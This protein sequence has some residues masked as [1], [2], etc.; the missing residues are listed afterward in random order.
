[1]TQAGGQYDDVSS[2]VGNDVGSDTGRTSDESSTDESWTDV[3]RKLDRRPT[4][5]GRKSNGRPTKVGRVELS[6][7]CGDGGRR[8]FLPTLQ[9]WPGALQLAVLLWRWPAMHCSL[10]R[11]CG[12]A[13]ATCWTSQRCC[14][15]QQR[16]GPHGVAAMAG[17]ALD[18]AV[19]CCDV[20]QRAGPRNIAV[21]QRAGPRSV[22]VQQRAGPRSVA[23]QQR[24]G[25]RS[26]AT[27][28]ALQLRPTLRCNGF[29]FFFFFFTR[30]LEERKRMEKERSFDTC[31]L[32]SRLRLS[33]LWLVVRNAKLLATTSVATVVTRSFRQQQHE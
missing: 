26:V 6:R 32:V 8:R 25:P 7:R 17:S 12:A 19:C 18:L 28:L 3:R 24:A 4:K 21:R 27:M 15:G 10:Q 9:Q 14:N 16:A 5:V 22:A 1:M 29:G 13:V 33:L 23:V 2:D 11:S 30:Q 20:R 31:S